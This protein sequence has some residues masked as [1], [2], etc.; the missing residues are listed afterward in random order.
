MIQLLPPYKKI[1]IALATLKKVTF[2]FAVTVNLA[3]S[4]NTSPEL[5]EKL[6]APYQ[7]LEAAGTFKE[8]LR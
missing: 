4:K 8:L 2:S 7:A 6:R 3:F 5:V 1:N